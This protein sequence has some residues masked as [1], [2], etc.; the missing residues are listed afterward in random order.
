[1]K[2]LLVPGVI[3]GLSLC[4]LFSLAQHAEADPFVVHNGDMLAGF[5]KTGSHQGNYE[6]VVNIGNITNF[7]K[8][9]PGAS[10]TIDHYV[11]S[12]LLRAFSDLNNLQWSVS[13]SFPG[14]SRWAGFPSST[15][16][17]TVLRTNSTSQSHPPQ[18]TPA[19]VQQLTRQTMI[20]V[21]SGAVSI[22][23]SLGTS[24]LDNNVY[25]V[26][27]PIN[28]PNDLTTFIGGV[29]NSTIGTF[30][31]TLPFSVENI[32][33]GNFTATV[34]SDLYQSCPSGTADPIT[35]AMTGAAYWVGVFQL[36]PDGTMSFVRASSSTPPPSPP[37][38][39]LTVS[40][41]ATATTISFATT[42][43][44]TYT[45]YYTNLTGLSQPPANWPSAPSTISGDGTTKAFIDSTTD[46]DRFYRVGA[47]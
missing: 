20:G 41:S 2:I 34:A 32:T 6:V 45:L 25:L 3:V 38:P 28:D 12:Q 35:G 42:N 22:S 39:V 26:R 29:F 27:E 11:S 8:L 31:D 17:Y 16:W 14:S 33:P 10:M 44:A 7:E 19:S 47:R 46:P 1:M 40:R 21:G 4:A 15:L 9:Q 5:R 43:G 23:T 13:G 37:A 18:R 30:Q 24:N 36:Q